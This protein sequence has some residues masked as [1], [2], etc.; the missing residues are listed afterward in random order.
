MEPVDQVAFYVPL[1]TP[2]PCFPCHRRPWPNAEDA[3]A[4]GVRREEPLLPSENNAETKTSQGTFSRDVSD[5]EHAYVLMRYFRVW[6]V[7]YAKGGHPNS[8]PGNLP[9]SFV[10][11]SIRISKLSNVVMHY[12]VGH[13]WTKI[14][15]RICG[16]K[17]FRC[18]I[19]LSLIIFLEFFPAPLCILTKY[20]PLWYP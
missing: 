8:V 10:Y 2:G 7:N 1:L 20:I 14:C 4:L 9:S 12:R 3:E 5:N 18:S 19:F 13:K 15:F 6:G 17:G 11:S 16:A